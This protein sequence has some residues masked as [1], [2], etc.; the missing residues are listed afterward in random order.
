MKMLSWSKKS[1][2]SKLRLEML[3]NKV[4]INGFQDRDTE[5]QLMMVFRAKEYYEEP[6]NVKE[7]LTYMLQCVRLRII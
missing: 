6:Q 3:E 1:L 5:L 7:F 2:V 4:H